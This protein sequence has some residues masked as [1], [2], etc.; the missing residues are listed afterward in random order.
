MQADQLMT[1]GYL[2]GLA[3]EGALDDAIDALIAEI[4]GAAPLAIDGMAQTIREMQAGREDPARTRKR[5]AASWAS[6][7]LKEGLAAI[8][9]RR[10]PAFTG[11]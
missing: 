11:R 4:R 2:D 6:E 3:P 5:I 1:L 7:D 8:K 10:K 9:A